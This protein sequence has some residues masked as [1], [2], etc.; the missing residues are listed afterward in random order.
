MFGKRSDATLVRNLDPM[1]EFMPYISPGRN[2]SAFYM[3]HV[4]KVDAAYE[5]LD[6]VN[7]GRP[8]GR[9]ITLFHLLLRSCAQSFYLRPGV[10]RFV[11]GGKLWQRDGIW[12]SFAAKTRHRDGSP[13]I[14]IKHRFYPE[15][16][17]LDEM[18]DAIYDRLESGRSGKQTTSDKEVRLLLRLPG[19]L[20]KMVLALGRMADNLGLMPRSM[21]DADP[22]CCS[23][24][25]ANLGSIGYPAGFHHLWEHGT[26]SI[27]AAMGR[28]ERTEDRRRTITVAWTYDERIEDGFYSHGT[29]AMIR[30]RIERPD[31]LADRV[32]PPQEKIA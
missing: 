23:I 13:M 14:T 10:N 31:R 5:F 3:N 4:I 20:L 30:K 15:S 17:T 11:K 26:C 27:F 22:L 12:F 32:T 19:P 8:K 2:A 1:R 29:L 24:F 25:L 18:V 6:K 16:E 21:L 7:Q 28:I 9:P